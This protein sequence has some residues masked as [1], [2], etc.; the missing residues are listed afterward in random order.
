M[1][2]FAAASSSSKLQ[3]DRDDPLDE[4]ALPDM[5]FSDGLSAQDQEAALADLLSSALDLDAGDNPAEG[6]DEAPAELKC[7]LLPH[8]VQ[9]LKWLKGREEGKKRGGILADDMGLGKTVQMLALILAN[10]NYNEK[11]IRNSEGKRLKTTLVRRL[12]R[13]EQCAPKLTFFAPTPTPPSRLPS[14]SLSC[15]T[16]AF[17]SHRSFAPSRSWSSGRTRFS[18]SPT[19]TSKFASTTAR[20][21]SRVRLV[22]LL[23]YACFLVLPCHPLARDLE[24]G[25]DHSRSSC[26][27]TACTDH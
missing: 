23:A 14:P 27:R 12:C 10:P 19:P 7:T 2:P 18:A 11:V 26:S 22:L 25:A 15:A 21:R 17:L 16:S 1:R 3:R 24:L 4:D 5:G 9:G 8:Q 6:E 20:A 13:A